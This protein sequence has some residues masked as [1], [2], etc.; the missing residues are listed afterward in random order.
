MK[1]VFSILALAY[2]ILTIVFAILEQTHDMCFM[3]ILAIWC[4]TEAHH[5]GIIDEMKRK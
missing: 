2:L 4:L 1:Y 5:S 3:G